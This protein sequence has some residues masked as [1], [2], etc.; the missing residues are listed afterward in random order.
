MQIQISVTMVNIITPSN[1]TLHC[2]CKSAQLCL[3]VDNIGESVKVLTRIE[4]GIHVSLT[5]GF[6]CVDFPKFF[7]PRGQTEIKPT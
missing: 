6:Y 3:S 1:Q 5:A 7:Q 2:L 4:D